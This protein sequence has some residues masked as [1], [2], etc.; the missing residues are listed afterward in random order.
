TYEDPLSPGTLLEMQTINAAT[1]AGIDAEV[2]SLESGK[3]ADVVV[4]SARAAESY[5]A[6]NPLHLLA[7]TM[8][9]GSVE[10]VLVNGEVV[11]SGGHSTRVDEAE[12][13]RAVSDSVVGR[14]DRL[15]IGLDP[16]WP[17]VS[18]P[19]APACSD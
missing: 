3:R 9:T 18:P 8:G 2:G 10:T 14:A 11:F 7:L 17:V 12:A 13:Y 5:P 4:R 15:G 6:N 16:E 1:A 19:A